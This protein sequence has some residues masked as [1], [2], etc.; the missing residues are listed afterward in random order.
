MTVIS[1]EKK[2]EQVSNQCRAVAHLAASLAHVHEDLAHIFRSGGPQDD[3]L[4]MNGQRTAEL[5]EVL[6][7]ILNGMDAVSDD[8]RWID[9]IM[10]E[11]H[12]VWPPSSAGT[13]GE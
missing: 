4:E 1:I 9:P 6:G 10:V 7:N 5:L 11:A 13:E 3:I 8:D 12:R 2:R